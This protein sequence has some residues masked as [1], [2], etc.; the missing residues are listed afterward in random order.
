[1]KKEYVFLDSKNVKLQLSLEKLKEKNIKKYNKK[2]SDLAMKAAEEEAEYIII[3]SQLS[4]KQIEDLQKSQIPE[5]K[6]VSESIQPVI[7]ERVYDITSAQNI[8]EASGIPVQEFL[9][10][11]RSSSRKSRQRSLLSRFMRRR[12]RSSSGI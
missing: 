4:A 11:S 12:S 6:P 3:S 10:S 5:A 1:M 9:P 7:A 2:L 8:P